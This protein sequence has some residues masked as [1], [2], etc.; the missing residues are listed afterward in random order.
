LLCSNCGYEN[1]KEHRYCGMCGTPFPH[2]AL[3]V[4]GAQSTVEF[5]SAP[6]EVPPKAVYDALAEPEAIVQETV[7]ASVTEAEPK[8]PEAVTA[9]SP[10][11]TEE[12]AGA[13]A[14]GPA[15][16]IQAG[17]MLHSPAQADA[18]AAFVE[19]P[20]A[21]ETLADVPQAPME[22][23]AEGSPVETVPLAAEPQ[24]E[25]QSEA[26]GASAEAAAPP[27]KEPEQPVVPPAHEPEPE[28]PGIR[29]PEPEAPEV[30]REPPPPPEQEPPTPPQR[31][32][33]EVAPSAAPTRP[34]PTHAPRVIVMP[35]RMAEGPPPEVSAQDLA[36]I[37]PPPDS[38]PINLPPTSSGMPT[39]KEISEASGPPAISPFEPPKET[40][41]A[42]DRELEEFVAQFR[43]TPPAETADELTMRSEVPVID[44]EAPAE[45]HHPSFDGDEAPPPQ[46]GPHPTGQ[47]Y[48]TSEGTAPRPRFLDVGD[49]SSGG[50][51]QPVG[52]GS[53]ILGIDATPAIVP[54]DVVARTS[55]RR[56]WLIGSILALV[57]IFGGLGYLEGRAQSTHAF[58]GPAE[59]AREGYSDARQWLRKKIESMTAAQPGPA[60]ETA[61]AI[62]P[63]NQEASAAQAVNTQAENPQ[64]NGTPPAGD[65]QSADAGA[66]SEPT[67]TGPPMPI[68]APLPKPSSK[69]QPGQMELAKAMNASDAAAMAAW[70]WKATSRG[71]P[72]APVR[73]AD[74]YIRGNGVPKSCEQ[75]LV[76]LRAAAAKENAPARNRLAALYANGS[77]V[78]RDP[79][80]AYQLLSSALAADPN[81][82]WARENQQVLWN[83]MTA[84]QRVEA[85]RVQ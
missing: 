84:A 63:S 59:I 29:E 79:V 13:E 72:D 28:R 20:A 33:A 5:I 85:K 40:L 4:P 53:S 32:A 75:A 50:R 60:P 70:L 82:E 39:F 2:R 56:W 6:V 38:L 68:E 24:R 22:F 1:P 51:S 42:E 57:A 76:L 30:I 36:R 62:E 74:M 17:A 71:N 78:A 12:I 49:T 67:Q 43:W 66:G 23:G 83:Q 41:A 9:D 69:P 16:I 45:F 11:A 15:T 34:A 55:R 47:E 27:V 26:P 3:S 35:P 25:W 65:T 73:L 58:R 64:P 31:A 21:R 19:E 54:P 81:S 18:A 52:S 77:C 46:A 8:Q 61:K 37:H 44:K 80:K 48:Y 7:A 10:K 14:V